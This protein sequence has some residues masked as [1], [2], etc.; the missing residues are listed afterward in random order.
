MFA[1][2]GLTC[3]FY[4]WYPYHLWIYK[5]KLH[6][7]STT[8]STLKNSSLINF[9]WLFCNTSPFLTP[10]FFVHFQI[11]IF[12]M[13]DQ[14]MKNTQPRGSMVIVLYCVNHLHRSS[15]V[16]AQIPQRR[17]IQ[18][19]PPHS[20]KFHFHTGFRQ[21][22]HQYLQAVKARIHGYTHPKRYKICI[23]DCTTK[24]RKN[25]K[26]KNSSYWVRVRDSQHNLGSLEVKW[27]KHNLEEIAQA[28]PWQVLSTSGD[29][30]STVLEYSGDSLKWKMKPLY[31]PTHWAPSRM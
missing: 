14:S 21:H 31:L 17:C 13:R 9:L 18:S 27:V 22:I 24:N 2:V 4:F 10:P 15:S 26:S 28:L 5:F 19:L 8:F 1:L 6:I 3:S 20:C 25:T 16:R 30:D 7:S 29:G 11:F 23:V 12:E